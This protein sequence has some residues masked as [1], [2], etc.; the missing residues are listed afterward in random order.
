MMGTFCPNTA[1][2]ACKLHKYLKKQVV[3]N[4]PG[5]EGNDKDIV[6]LQIKD[7][8]KTDAQNNTPNSL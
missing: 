2:K 4:Y 8:L 5:D 1:Y 3:P 7:E 6:L